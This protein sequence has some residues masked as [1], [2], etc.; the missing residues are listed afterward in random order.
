[1]SWAAWLHSAVV[2]VPPRSLKPPPTCPSRAAA[3]CTLHLLGWAP[4]SLRVLRPPRLYWTG[5]G[6]QWPPR[7]RPWPRSSSRQTQV[8][9]LELRLRVRMS[10]LRPPAP[11]P[12]LTCIGA[13]PGQPFF[14]T[15]Q[16]LSA[17][18]ESVILPQEHATAAG[19]RAS[20]HAPEMVEGEQAV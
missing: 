18:G 7:R 20:E 9:S 10:I 6:S 17:V 15:A 14:Q 19:Q 3:L 2:E 13:N 12:R 4:E 8:L 1:M 16:L 5:C 11:L